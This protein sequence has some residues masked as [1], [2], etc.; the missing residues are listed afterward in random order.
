MFGF[1]KDKLKSAVEKF[2]KKVEEEVEVIEEKEIEEKQ[3]VIKKAKKAEPKILEIEEILKEDKEEKKEVKE[4]SFIKKITEKVTTKKIS[5]EQFEEIFQDLQI[6]LLENNVA[7]EVVDKIKEDLKEE[8]LEKPIKRIQIESQVKEAL[9][10][11]L[12]EILTPPEF[13]LIK[14]IEKAKKESRPAVILIIGYNGSGKSLS[15]AKLAHY[16]KQKKYK[17]ILAAADTFRAAGAIQLVEYG[18]LAEIPVIHDP[19]TKD[20]CSVIFDTIKH[21]KSKHYDIVVA[22]TSGRIQ[23]NKDLMDEL[24]KITRI[25]NPDATL[26]VVDSLTGSDVVIQVDQF[27]KN[28]AVDG[29]ILTKV[30]VDEKGGA[31]LSAVYTGKKPVLFVCLGQRITDIEEYNPEKIVKQLGL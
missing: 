31:F 6:A 24:K 8:L 21:A 3:P 5:E 7:L 29:L 22:D 13:D 15:C 17:P 14:T 26:L 16:L 25:N 28:I 9:R 20:S 18:K 30:D 11:S 12:E 2:T 4:K 27:D 19:K 23:N 10:K 1:L